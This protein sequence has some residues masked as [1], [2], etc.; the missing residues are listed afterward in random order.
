MDPESDISPDAAPA[1][2]SPGARLG[3]LFVTKLPFLC[4]VTA[5]AAAE[6]GSGVPAREDTD[7]GRDAEFLLA[8]T[9]VTPGSS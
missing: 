4:L 5:G 1:G 8:L 2:R 6:S 9:E 3:R 7:G